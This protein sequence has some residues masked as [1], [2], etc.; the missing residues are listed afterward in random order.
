MRK[1]LT[2]WALLARVATADDLRPV[3]VITPYPAQ[4]SYRLGGN[5]VYTDCGVEHP[6]LRNRI[7]LPR[8]K[9]LF[10]RAEELHL[11]WKR[12]GEEALPDGN[13]DN[14][15][16]PMKPE[17]RWEQILPVC[18]TP[19]LLLAWWWKKRRDRQQDQ[20]LADQEPLIRS[21][22]QVPR[23][24]LGGYRLR[25][26]LGTGAMGVVYLAEN[27]QGARC[28]IK[29]PVHNF[30]TDPDFAPRFK[31]ELELGLVLQHPR[32]V[33][34]LALPVGSEPYLMMEF[35]P[36]RTLDSVPPLPLGEELPR[37]WDWCDQLLDGLIF[38]HSQ[39]I[40]HR[41]IKP[42]NIMIDEKDEAKLM[43]FGV[44]HT[45]ERTR[46]TATGSVLGTP[47]FMAPEQVQGVPCD[48]SIDIYALGLV[49][50]ERLTGRRLPFPEDFLELLR[51]K[52]SQPLP[53]LKGKLPGLPDA[54]ADFLDALGAT[55]PQN[56]PSAVQAREWLHRL[57]R[58]SGG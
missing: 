45:S 31:R 43:D 6:G 35:V 11:F 24:S 58:A 42:A 41:D 14:L 53:S 40:I 56:R 49:L 55:S 28:A 25:S 23:R 4:I 44:A 47:V 54:W 21:D 20:A 26:I 39:G 48:P 22:G 13:E 36:G 50:Y 1:M 5:D 34:L 18:L 33:R 19:L 2:A 10:V 52:L 38:V 29:V 7:Q 17:P 3:D 9:Q 30:L 16:V 12:S 57:P 15:K 37:C 27:P 32:I 46:L 51:V 8:E